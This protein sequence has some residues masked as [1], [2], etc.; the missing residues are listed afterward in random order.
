MARIKNKGLVAAMEGETDIVVCEPIQT[1]TPENVVACSQAELQLRDCEDNGLID[2]ARV[3]DAIQCVESLEN[4]RDVMSVAAEN[5]GVDRYSAAAVNV[6]LESLFSRAGITSHELPAM[7]AYGGTS[8][9]TESTTLAIGQ[10]NSGLAKIWNAIIE[11]MKKFWEWIK[12]FFTNVEKMARAQLERAK[13]LLTRKPTGEPNELFFVNKQLAETLGMGDSVPHDFTEKL[14]AWSRKIK[15]LFQRHD[16]YTT[17]IAEAMA[18][19]AETSLTS[20]QPMDININPEGDEASDATSMFGNMI[21]DDQT[22]ESAV[23]GDEAIAAAAQMAHASVKKAEGAPEVKENLATLAANMIGNTIKE[24]SD[25]LEFIIHAASEGTKKEVVNNRIIGVMEKAKKAEET[26][27]EGDK[28]RFEKIKKVGKD[29]VALLS[30]WFVSLAGYVVRVCKATLDYVEES[31]RRF[32]QPSEAASVNPE[33]NTAAPASAQAPA[34]H[35]PEPVA[36]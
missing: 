22:P 7:E 26:V 2:D 23:S 33:N 29:F 13:T 31:L 27:G 14:G 32:T 18:G 3:D 28:S 21:F 34:S 5:G 30:K 10:I 6:A 8:S 24:V 25:L 1:N 4:I 16:K 15:S 35:P 19:A 20:D 9:R 11:A 12:N 17:D 36:A